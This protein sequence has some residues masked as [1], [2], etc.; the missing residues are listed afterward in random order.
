MSARG[1]KT[2]AVIIVFLLCTTRK[3]FPVISPLSLERLFTIC[4]CL[5][6]LRLKNDYCILTLAPVYN[7]IFLIPTKRFHI[8]MGSKITLK[9]VTEQQSR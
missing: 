2:M 6:K 8:L 3:F 9:K 1:L 4:A 7:C 5:C